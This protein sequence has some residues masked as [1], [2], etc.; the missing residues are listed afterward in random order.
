MLLLY[1]LFFISTVPSAVSSEASREG[2]KL[3]AKAGAREGTRTPMGFLPQPPQGCV[4]ANFTTPAGIFVYVM[5]FSIAINSV[6]STVFYTPI[7]TLFQ[8]GTP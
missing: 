3:Y 4:S 6:L 2:G 8:S 5:C 7:S 1:Q